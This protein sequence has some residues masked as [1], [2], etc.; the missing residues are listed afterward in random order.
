MGLKTFRNRWFP[1][2]LS[3]VTI[4]SIGVAACSQ[5]SA[6][7]TRARSS[8]TSTLEQIIATSQLKIGYIVFPPAIVKNQTTGELGGHFV[9]TIEEIARINNWTPEFIETN[10][11]G[12]ATGLDSRRFDVS[13]APT[14]VTIPRALSV[15]FTRPLFYAGNSAIVKA[16]ETRFTTLESIDRPEV[17]VA[18][19]QGE[20]GDEYVKAN[21]KNAKITR[22]SGGDQSLAFQAVVA[23]RADIALGDAYVTSQF[24]RANPQ[25]KDLF[26]DAPYNLTPISWA[27]RKGDD[28]MLN[29][30]N[31]SLESLDYQGR[32]R[33]WEQQAGANWLHVKKVWESSA[34]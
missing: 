8:Q 23:G 20:A 22:F 25:V 28:Q 34:S 13:I 12:F 32:L 6:Q 19:T 24:A 11:S 17:T 5:D 18:V 1:I 14:F 7:Q 2:F 3:L 33:E 10:W 27:V 4:F 16:N 30:F 15:Y 21:F 26:A 9:E 31:S 29:F